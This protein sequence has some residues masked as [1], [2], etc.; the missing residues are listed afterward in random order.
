MQEGTTGLGRVT[1]GDWKNF[2][3]FSNSPYIPCYSFIGESLNL[4]SILVQRLAGQT[5]QNT[6]TVVSR[7][8]RVFNRE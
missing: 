8:T 1:A 4:E 7:D 2:F 6:N 5:A 3:F